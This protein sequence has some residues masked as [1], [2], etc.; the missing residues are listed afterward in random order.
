[1][2]FVHLHLHT[3]YSFL[4]G[5]VKP[6]EL[7][8]NL[9]K[10]NM[11]A[12]AVTDHGNMHG[13]I[14]FYTT[15]LGRGKSLKEAEIKP[16][17]GMEAYISSGDRTEKTKQDA[18]HIILLAKNN[19]GYK[20]LC[21]ISSQ[22]YI[23][24]F[25]YR[26]R[27]DRALLKEHANG[28]IAF[29][30]CLGGEIPKA[31]MAGRYE[32][33]KEI[34]YEYQELFGKDD[35]Y[36]EIQVNGLKEQEEANKLLIKLARETGTGLVATNDVHYI[37][38]EH[39]VAQDILFCI[40]EKKKVDDKNRMHHE[41]DGFYLKSEEEMRDLFSIYGEAG[42]EAIENTW[43]IAEKCNV[44]LSLNIPYLPDF[45]THGKTDSEYLAD[46][47]KEGLEEKFIELGINEEKKKDYYDRLQYELEMIEKTGFASYFLIVSDFIR[48]AKDN[49]IPVG[50]GRGSGAGSLVAYSTKITDLDPLRFGLVFE[51]FLNPE[52]ISMPDFDIDFCQDK[53]ELVIDYVS[54]KYGEANVA[55][56]ATFGQLKAK[57]AVRDVARALNIPLEVVNQLAKI[58]P[59]SLSD[60]LYP[61]FSKKVDGITKKLIDS[62][63]IS[64]ETANDPDL[65]RVAIKK[66]PIEPSEDS[67]VKMLSEEIDIYANERII[68][69]NNDDYKKII[70]IAS[71]IE[72]LL[73]QPGKHAC[74]LV[75]GQKPIYEY[76]P[77]F[78]DKEN[79]RV[80]QYDKEMVERVGLVKFDFLGL[81]TL[82]MIDNASNLIKKKNPDFDINKIPLDDEAT[83]KLLCEK[84]TQGI[85]QMESP[86][87]EKMIHQ[88][89]P[90]R[91]EDLIAAVAL[92]RP[93]PMDIIPNYI[94]RKQGKEEIEYEHEGLKEILNET[95]GLIVYQ[96]QVMQISRKMAGFTLGKADILRKA[97]GKKLAK[98]MEK[99][100]KE[101]IEGALELSIDKEVA[102]KV[103][104]HMEKFASYG[105]NKSHAACYGYIAYQT[106]YLK[107]HYPVEFFAALISSESDNADKVFRY[108]NDARL[109]GVEIYSPDIN[110]SDHS[111]LIEE[112][113][114]RF[115]LGAIKNV[116]VGAIEAAIEER[117]KNGVFESLIDFTTR[118][119]QSK[120]NSRT[121][122]F[123]IKSGAFDFTKINR[124]LLLSMLPVAIKEGEK[125]A[126]DKESGQTNLFE[127][128]N[129]VGVECK[130]CDNDEAI[131]NMVEN[132]EELDFLD[133]L[134]FEKEAL[135]IYLSNHPVNLFSK[136]FRNL[137]IKSIKEVIEEAETTRDFY[138]YK[139][140]TVWVPGI[141]TTDIKPI[142]GR[143]G[144]YY[145]KGVMEGSD[146]A[147]EFTIN[148]LEG[149]LNTPSIEKLSSK[150]PLLFLVRVKINRNY[151]DNTLEKISFNIEDI[152]E[153]VKTLSEYFQGNSKNIESM[154]VKAV[155]KISEK[156]FNEKKKQI[157]HSLLNKNLQGK[158]IKLELQIFFNE[159]EDSAL[160]ESSV[161]VDFNKISEY[162]QIFGYKNFYLSR[163]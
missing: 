42:T 22:S 101:F 69:K 89:K 161:N 7:F 144:D 24:G 142:K 20:N 78:V 28:L 25:Y 130:A 85:F 92:Y 102:I 106:A 151:D 59:D 52:R 99:M 49:D 81:K 8:D 149:F 5:L 163:G 70:E 23:D 104:D 136:D 31:L 133:S 16:I 121:I 44:E 105:F 160:F 53:R 90:D 88:M 91:I 93:G 120:V 109:M 45:E 118:V 117:G 126:A 103:F 143:D 68:I 137:G 145:L 138:R 38:P 3:I 54:K 55:Q 119:S 94:R 124:G 35:F 98:E 96:E 134:F 63:N 123:L 37:K 153:G 107:T 15:M 162:K 32:E 4:D 66:L 115:G 26:P 13:A 72:G 129:I 132:K 75:I 51:R 9:K 97:M 157:S 110:K 148:K 82:T 100:K 86:G 64:A 60:L 79:H 67:L 116:G 113:S 159:G 127:A 18:F 152:K 111:F 112:N 1:M 147:A 73:R 40:N 158:E 131:L 6:T 139:S 150:A 2:S 12:V 146:G 58:V 74:G 36:I 76:S 41:S 122:E 62:Y 10:L 61:Q 14:D 56:I 80:T 43:K 71:Q 39:A 19:E 50:P 95:F 47:A 34:V 11:N 83:Y 46:L 155:A 128:F 156:E 114:I 33:A 154:T 48:W 65:L 84:S 108:I 140:A 21:Y 141:I 135:G 17:I 77:L 57:S 125:I 29:S 27:I 30:A 87:F